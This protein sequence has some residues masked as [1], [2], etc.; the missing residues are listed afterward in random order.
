ML[1]LKSFDDDEILLVDDDDKDHQYVT[2]RS[3]IMINAASGLDGCDDQMLPASFRAMEHELGFSPSLLGNITLAQTM[4]LSVSCPLWGF[5][6]DRTSRKRVLCLGCTLW[7]A[8]TVGLASVSA[9]WQVVVLRMLNGFFMGSIGPISQS[10]LADSSKSEDRGFTFGLVQTC[11]NFGRV[12]GGVTTTAIGLQFFYGIS[13]WRY[14][15]GTVGVLSM[16]LGIVILF[17]LPPIPRR[18]SRSMLPADIKLL[19]ARK[20]ELAGSNQSLADTGGTMLE[21]NSRDLQPLLPRSESLPF[22]QFW[23]ELFRHSLSAPSVWLLMAEGFTGMIP[24]SALSFMT[25]F[26]QYC[27]LS[28]LEAGFVTGA[29]LVGAMISGPVGGFIGDYFSQKAPNH[30]RPFIAQLSMLLRIPVLVLCFHLIQRDPQSFNEFFTLALCLGLSSF[31]GA[32][33]NRPILSDV[34]LAEHRAT[35]FSIVSLLQLQLY[36]S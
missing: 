33:V 18:L 29:M 13:G 3:L 27:G 9:Y 36:F 19:E 2:K 25:M 22:K 7:G 31:A 15:I 26:F 11:S 24:W 28:D 4:A 20:R 6:A 5:L 1:A 35:V 17:F 8:V 10:I 14:S 21:G 16:L 23:G 32:A 34:V 12:I 30:G